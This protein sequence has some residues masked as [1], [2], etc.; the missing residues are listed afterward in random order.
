MKTGIFIGV[1]ALGLTLFAAPE[2]HGWWN[3]GPELNL[4]LAGSSFVIS[5][6]DGEPTPASETSTSRQSGIATGKYTRAFITTSTVTQGPPAPD[7]SC[8]DELPFGEAATVTFVL[9]YRDGSLLTGE[10]GPDN[11]YCS[12]GVLFV[13]DV[14]GTITGGAGRFEGATGTWEARAQVLNSRF[15]G[16]LLIDLD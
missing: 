12:D 13:A 3:W 14:G 5:T 1:A 6:V 9:T 16:E 11:S 7:E 15:T 2:A 4:K 8:P 10:T